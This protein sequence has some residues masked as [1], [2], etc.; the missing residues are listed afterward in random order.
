MLHWESYQIAAEQ[1]V[2]VLLCCRLSSSETGSGSEGQGF[3]KM[4]T[5][6]THRKAS[7]IR[8]YLHVRLYFLE[9]I[10]KFVFFGKYGR[11]RERF[12][13]LSSN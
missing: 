1:V 5:P 10:C 8:K 3:T 11:V 4:T 6:L 2:T 13:S 7:T 12:H 9:Q